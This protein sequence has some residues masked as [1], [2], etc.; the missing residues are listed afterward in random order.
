MRI[1]LS[2]LCL[3]LFIACGGGGGSTSG[4][5]NPPPS[6]YT[7]QQNISA[8]GIVS[9]LPSGAQTVSATTQPVFTITL[10]TGYFIEAADVQSQN[11]GVLTTVSE[12]QWR[13]TFNPVSKNDVL[14]VVPRVKVKTYTV[15]CFLEQWPVQ[16]LVKT[17][18]VK[19]GERV[20][21]ENPVPANTIVR[22]FSGIYGYYTN[23]TYTSIPMNDAVYAKTQQ[24]KIFCHV[25]PVPQGCYYYYHT[26]HPSVVRMNEVGVK[27]LTITAEIYNADH[28]D[29]EY[30]ADQ[31]LGWFPT[32]KQ[33]VRMTKDSSSKYVAT[34]TPNIIP[35][36]TLRYHDG[37]M[38]RL[39]FNVIAKDSYG[40]VLQYVA[41]DKGITHPTFDVGIIP[42]DYVTT[43]TDLGNGVRMTSHA[44][45]I[46]K[47][48][49]IGSQIA[50]YL[51]IPIALQHLK[52][53]FE[54]ITLYSIGQSEEW[55]GSYHVM[56]EHGAKGIGIDK[57]PNYRLPAPGDFGSSVLKGIQCIRHANFVGSPVVH[58]WGHK[59]SIF[60][61]HASLKLTDSSDAHPVSISS[62][63]GIMGS[64]A[65][66]VEENGS[67]VYK[68]IV[69]E[70]R[71]KFSFLDLYTH[72]L[73]T[74]AEVGTLLWVDPSWVPTTF[75]STIPSAYVHATTIDGIEQVYGQIELPA[76][77]GLP[78]EERML[79]LGVSNAPVSDEV[80]FFM[81]VNAKYYTES[82]SYNPM[83]TP[84]FHYA[85][86]GRKTINAEILSQRK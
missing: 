2:M 78:K 7:I 63:Y 39:Q 70:D 1:M 55:N 79:F 84:N 57:N 22:E 48:G 71:S 30:Y 29:V 37:M 58:E 56:I 8:P 86:R 10:Q 38:D 24:G 76:Y 41:S 85:L 72:G 59:R 16:T 40:N 62:F 31:L 35:S 60:Y 15:Q 28:V 11:G 82:T 18:T 19:E 77:D 50:R 68:E 75:G 12:T 51:A 64:S 46:E 36:A 32:Q 44:M 17:V 26:V 67:S 61:S 47:P 14:V 45:V 34:F 3:V 54:T 83:V 21:W 6:T 69:Q 23:N 52:D 25:F 43:I 80:L 13:Y 42:N 5:G 65:R 66:V 49:I 33:V 9:V 27:S 81:H 74:K 20:V 4:G 73:A 53:S